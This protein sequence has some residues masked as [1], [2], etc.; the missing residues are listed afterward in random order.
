VDAIFAIHTAPLEL[1]VRGTLMYWFLF[2]V[3]RFVLR[4]DSSGVGIA[5]I[6]FIVLVADASQNA[7]SGSYGS[8]TEGCILV[9]TLVAWNFAMDWASMH[10]APVRRFLEPRPVLLIRDGRMIR[11]N[12]RQEF[13]TPEDVEAQMREH[14]IASI[15]EVRRA[16]MESDGKLSFLTR[17][18]PRDDPGEPPASPGTAGR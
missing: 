6:L 5:D 7:M 4:R 13:L 11:R 16:Y 12:L 15:E 9:G 18:R 2:L 8:V 17:D 14:D 3:F 10:W 1:V